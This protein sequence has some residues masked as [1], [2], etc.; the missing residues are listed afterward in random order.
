MVTAGIFSFK[1]NSHGRAGNRTRNL[2]I[3]SQ[4]LWPQEHEAG[5]APHCYN[6]R[7]VYMVLRVLLFY[8]V[9]IV[10]PAPHIHFHLHAA[11]TTRTKGRSLR[12]FRG[13]RSFE[14]R[15]SFCG[16]TRLL[17]LEM[18]GKVC[19]VLRFSN[20][21]L[22]SSLTLFWEAWNSSKWYLTLWRRNYF[23]LILAHPVYKTWIIQEPNKLAL[24]NKLHFEEKKAEI[25][26]HV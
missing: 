4:R 3:S 2:M 26:E 1:E 18:V 22:P 24:W 8:P 9:N 17:H 11:F 19:I 16:N 5:H 21:L 13:Q 23:F 7:D 12:I 14:I 10:S 6:I 25:I 20:F 15:R